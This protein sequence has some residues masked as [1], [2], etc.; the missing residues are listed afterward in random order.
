M[1][2][3]LKFIYT[4][5]LVGLIIIGSLLLLTAFPIPGIDLDARVVQSGSMEPAIRTGSVIFILP[6]KEYGVD[7]IITYR[8][9]ER[10]TPTTH[11]IVDIDEETGSF[12][13]KGDANTAND[14][15][16]VK[17]ENILGSVRFHIPFL[18]FVIHFARQP[19]GF[20]LLVILPAIVIGADEVRK[21]A[22]EIRND[23]SEPRRKERSVQKVAKLKSLK[24]K[25][26]RTEKRPGQEIRRTKVIEPRAYEVRERPR[27]VKR[28]RLDMS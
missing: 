8:M 15:S 11:R 22:R 19:L 16:T 2:K 5:S 21:I 4:L 18:G 28:R 6:A 20:F 17:E 12:I 10:E 9:E 14:I 23:K 1:R 27:P 7:D 24:P 13:T 3:L 25:I 26:P